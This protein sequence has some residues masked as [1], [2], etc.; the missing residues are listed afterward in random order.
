[1][2]HNA[3]ELDV[4]FLRQNVEPIRRLGHSYYM[5]RVIVVLEKHHVRNSEMNII[6][7][8]VFVHSVCEV[9][10]SKLPKP[11]S[12]NAGDLENLRCVDEAPCLSREERDASLVGGK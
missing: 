3:S 11:K 12:S 1:V 4:G 9:D 10:G 8:N 7:K 2:H 6:N 5:P